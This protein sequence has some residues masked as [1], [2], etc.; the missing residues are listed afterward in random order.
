MQTKPKAK[1]P[2]H[3]ILPPVFRPTLRSSA[4]IRLQSP[5]KIRQPFQAPYVPKQFNVHA[6]AFGSCKSMGWRVKTETSWHIIDQDV[7]WCPD[8]VAHNDLFR[9]P[10]NQ[11]NERLSLYGVCALT[12]SSSKRLCQAIRS[13]GPFH[14]PLS[15]LPSNYPQDPAE[16]LCVISSGS[17]SHLNPSLRSRRVVGIC[18]SNRECDRETVLFKRRGLTLGISEIEIENGQITRGFGQFHEIAKSENLP[19]TTRAWPPPPHVAQAAE[20]ERK[21]PPQK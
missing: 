8:V 18:S 1:A 6:S 10:S 17:V 11:A 20:H 4:A 19:A 16:C 12:R 14:Q 3:S 7:M 21:Y 5:G 13:L 15:I 2:H 9:K